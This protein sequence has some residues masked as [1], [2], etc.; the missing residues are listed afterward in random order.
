MGVTRKMETR[1]TLQRRQ[2]TGMASTSGQR[3]AQKWI[4]PYR[5]SFVQKLQPDDIQK[6]VAY[7]PLG[8]AQSV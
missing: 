1:G 2:E 3:A 4:H 7:R 5:I 8:I 6:L